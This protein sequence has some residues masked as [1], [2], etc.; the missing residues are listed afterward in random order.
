M[1]YLLDTHALIWLDNEP[2]RLSNTVSELCADKNNELLF[3]IASVW[4]MQIKLKLG[5]LN[6]PLPLTEMIMGQQKTNGI[7]LL[8]VELSHV[9]ELGT[10]PDYH[11]DPFDRM[12]IAQARIEST[13]LVS[14]DT[15]I[16]KYPI[17]VI[18]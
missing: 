13:I 11:K 14:D 2:N 9:V 18:W 17:S 15:Q 6:L 1:K 12:L 8:S 4:E 3:S 7:K 16:A 10:L 5:K